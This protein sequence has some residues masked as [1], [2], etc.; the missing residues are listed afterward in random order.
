MPHLVSP[1]PPASYA[2]VHVCLC[3]IIVCLLIFDIIHSSPELSLNY[4]AYYCSNVTL[5]HMHIC[6]LL[7]IF[8]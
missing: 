5:A 8:V 4:P 1:H 2:S 7:F 6:I 3:V